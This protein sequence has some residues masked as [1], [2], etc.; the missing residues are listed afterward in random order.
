MSLA[1]HPDTDRDRLDRL[2]AALDAMR[3]DGRYA[4]IVSE[5][6]ERNGDAND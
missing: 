5:V 1:C 4:A 3:E 2:Q 6:L